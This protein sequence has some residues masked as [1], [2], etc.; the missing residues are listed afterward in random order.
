MHSAPKTTLSARQAEIADLIAGGKSNREIAETL[1][2]SERTVETHVTAIFNKLNVRSRTELVAAV[3]RSAPSKAVAVGRRTN[4][5]SQLKSLVGR[6]AEVAQIRAAL[7][8][9]RL[10]TLTGAGGIGKTLTALQVGADLLEGFDG[11]VWLVELAPLSD[12]SLVASAIAR[13]LGVPESPNVPQIETLIAHLWRK[14][15][16]LLL[17]NCEHLVA[18]AAT[19]ADALL[20]GCPELR[21]LATSREPLKVAGE[22]AYRLPSLRVPTPDATRSLGASGA[23]AYGAIVL[24]S[25]RARAVD[26]RFTLTDQNAPIV[27]DICRR[28]DGIPFA[29]ELAAARVRI[30]SVKVLSERLHQCFRILTGGERAALPRQQTMRALI[31][32]SYDL[33][34]PPEQRLFDRFSIFAGGCSLATATAVCAGED[35]DE[36][37]VLDLLTSLVDKSLILADVDGIEPRYRLSESSRQYAH[38]KLLARGEQEAV[39]RRHALACLESA[40]RL[41]RALDTTQDRAWL[42]QAQPELENWRAALTWAL[43]ARGD[44]VVGQRLAAAARLL[45]ARV[46]LSEGRQW[47]RVALELVDNATPAALIAKL[48]Y[49]EAAFASILGQPTAALAAAERAEARFRVLGDSVGVAFARRVAGF[50]L[51]RLNRVA[52]GEA[53]LEE[54][55]EAAR[56]LGNQRLAGYVLSGMGAIPAVRAD[57]ERARALFVKEVEAWKAVGFEDSVVNAASNFAEIEFQ[58]GDAEA[59]LQHTREALAAR[60]TSGGPD[61]VVH[62]LQ[63]M[64][65]YLVALSRFDEARIHA[66]EAL[67]IAFELRLDVL[68]MCALHRLAAVAAL[69]PPDDAQSAAADR[70]RAALLFGFVDANFRR[71]DLS[72][73]YTEQQEF[74]RARTALSAE[75]GTHELER[76]MAVGATLTEARAIEEAVAI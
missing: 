32:W 57:L 15:L 8:D 37:D 48:E 16:L 21:I 62:N 51:V 46:A 43:R 58:C 50:S 7:Q 22:R 65:A 63:N 23:I 41:E 1:F 5:P 42:A 28:V 39:A 11:G 44:V 38:E 74:D 53:L 12:A 76:L 67:D 68:G 64:A 75:L 47:V 27:A 55:L 24:F 10:V 29:I 13:A 66:R 26:H 56:A 18:A 54:A 72:R 49:A 35:G 59:A 34:S 3:L 73:E 45:F 33:L 14:R 9:D 30:L 25:E 31:D 52:E 17:D 20:R 6:E 4:L 19:L 71:L 69:R 36:L 60:R 70:G 40:E 61:Q 2:L